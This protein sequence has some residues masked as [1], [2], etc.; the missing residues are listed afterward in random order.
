MR[1]VRATLRKKRVVVGAGAAAAAV[2]LAVLAATL[3]PQLIVPDEPLVTDQADSGTPTG[4]VEFREPSAGFALSYPRNWTRVPDTD[5]QVTLLATQGPA[6]SFQVRVLAL[7]NP[8]SLEQLPAAKQ[9]T[10]QIVAANKAVKLLAQPQQITVGGLPGYFYFYTFT[11]PV[12]GQ[13]GALTFFPFQRKIDDH[14][15]FPGI[16]SRNIPR[17]RQYLRP[18]N[19]ERPAAVGPH[20]SKNPAGP[21][22]HL[23][24]HNRPELPGVTCYPLVAAE[25]PSQRGQVFVVRQVLARTGIMRSGVIR[26]G[27]T[28]QQSG[29]LDR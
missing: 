26:C 16:T 18:D 28:G 25:Q 27:H 23:W 9:V 20:N 1:N 17:R 14:A 10:D 2:G 24:R 3:G 8:I 21:A 7:Q 22:P 29:H 15:G 13:T 19:R 6:Y 11:D 4:L 5:P 12:T